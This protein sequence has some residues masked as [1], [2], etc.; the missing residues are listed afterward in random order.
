MGIVENVK[1]VVSLCQKIDNLD[2][3]RKLLD[4]Q[5]DVNEL[6]FQLREKDKTIEQLKEAFSIKEKMICKSSAYFTIDE[7]NNIIDGPFCTRCFDS[8]DHKICRLVPVG[9]RDNPEVQ[10]QKC[11]V[12]FVSMDSMTFFLKIPGT[13]T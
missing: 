8:E 2:L 13:A 1:E 9:R 6:A 4:L 7:N 3:Y 11:K 12:K 10:C 5:A